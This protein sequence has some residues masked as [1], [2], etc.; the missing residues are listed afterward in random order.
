MEIQVPPGM[1]SLAL[2]LPKVSQTNGWSR[3]AMF[4]CCV[5]YVYTFGQTVAISN[6][7]VDLV[8]LD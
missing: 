7:V 2:T 3:S 6:V 1:M 4:F 8:M 5:G